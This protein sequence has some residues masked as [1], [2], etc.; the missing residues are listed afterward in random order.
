M[1]NIQD[2]IV[3]VGAARTPMG[4]FQSDFA[5]LSAHDLGGAAIKAAGQ[6]SDTLGG[7]FEVWVFDPIPG[8]GSHVSGDSRLDGRIG[9][10]V[11]GIQAIKGVELGAVRFLQKPFGVATLARELRTALEE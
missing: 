5:S 7:I 6:D 9:Q 4:S 3:I 8:L 2:P 11:L 10:A 1:S